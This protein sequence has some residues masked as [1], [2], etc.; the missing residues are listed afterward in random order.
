MI[1]PMQTSRSSAGSA[2]INESQ[3]IEIRPTGGNLRRRAARVARQ[4]AVGAALEQDLR[5]RKLIAFRREVESR[6]SVF[7]VLRVDV[8][9]RVQEHADQFRAAVLNG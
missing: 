6:S 2:E 7:A 9:A 4:A 5:R 8:R 3:E 1:S